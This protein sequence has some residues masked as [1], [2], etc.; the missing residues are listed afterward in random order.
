[1]PRQAVEELGFDMDEIR[2]QEEDA[3]LGNGGLGRLAAC[4]M[5]SIATL[6]IPAYGYG[7]RYEYGLFFQQLVDGYQVE[8]PDNW[9]QNGTPWEFERQLPVFKIQFFGNVTSYQDENG[10]YR[11]Q[12]GQYQ[13]CHGQGQ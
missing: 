1:M 2:D 11:C 5:D 4:F 3:A 13:G 10:R 12:M 6:K 9:L 7:I 8:G